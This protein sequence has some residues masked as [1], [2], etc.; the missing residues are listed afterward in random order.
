MSGR[1]GHVEVAPPQIQTWTE[2]LL[3]LPKEKKWA[4]SNL[5]LLEDGA[6]LGD[7]IRSGQACAVSDG[8]FKEQFGTAAWVLYHNETHIMLGNG[9]LITPGC[10]QDQCAYHSKLSGLYGIA[11]TLNEL[12]IHQDFAGGHIKITCDRE[13]VLHRCFKPW[14][15]NPLAKHFDL[16]QA[17]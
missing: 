4:L 3:N 9:Q 5:T 7:A 14:D 2:H 10:P 13:S 15:S 11:L 12:S 8:S 1:Q 6:P 16:I 17:T